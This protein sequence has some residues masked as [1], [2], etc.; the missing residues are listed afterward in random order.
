MKDIVILGTG[1]HAK[2]ILW[3]LEDN[4]EDQKQWNILGFVDRNFQK[5]TSVAGYPILGDDQWLLNY[6]HPICA[7]CGIGNP[8]LRR[9]LV[10]QY[11]TSRVVFPSLVSRKAH[12][13]PRA[14]IGIGCIVF[15]S[16]VV[17]ID[18]VLEN[19]V[20][21][22]F[23]C[24]IGH[25]ARLCSFSGVNPCASVSGNVLVEQDCEIGTGAHIVQGIHI[26][27]ATTV[28]A[29]CVVIRDIPGHCTVVGNPGRILVR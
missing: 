26:G 13:S 15:S 25:D 14:A 9:K 1:G 24:S 5:G 22:Y 8:A 12:V 23:C 16:A 2:D 4:N 17:T 28:G 11:Q 18:V 6:K 27:P 29:G 10:S 19:F 20:Y 3:L 21:V 7:V